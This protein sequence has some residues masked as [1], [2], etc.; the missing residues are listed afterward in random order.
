MTTHGAKGLEA[1]IVIL[2]DT[3]DVRPRQTNEVVQ[4]PNG[5]PIWKPRSDLQP[6]AVRDALAAERAAQAEERLRLLYVAMTRAEKWLIVC[7]SGVVKTVVT[8]GTSGWKTVCCPLVLCRLIIPTAMDCGSS[9]A[10]GDLQKKQRKPKRQSLNPGCPNGRPGQPN[11]CWINLKHCHL[12][13]WRRQ[14]F[15]GGGR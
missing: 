15:A 5:L 1:P 9:M 13:I 7:A 11:L 4:M 12:Q 8:V 14:V 6:N 3:G 10:S 2:P